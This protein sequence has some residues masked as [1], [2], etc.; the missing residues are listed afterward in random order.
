MTHRASIATAP[1]FSGMVEAIAD[2]VAER[3]R[4]SAPP[5]LP[6][7]TPVIEP[8]E[9]YRHLHEICEA[10]YRLSTSDSAPLLGLKTLPGNA[11]DRHQV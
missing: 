2:Q 1:D 8:I 6:A 9:K 4:Q 5:Q 7:L 3:L 11:F 10:G